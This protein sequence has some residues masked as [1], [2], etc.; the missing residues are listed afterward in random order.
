MLPM[1]PSPPVY[2]FMYPPQQAPVSAQPQLIAGISNTTLLIG[3]A[4]LLLLVSRK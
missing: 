1:P 3:G 4:I 2:T